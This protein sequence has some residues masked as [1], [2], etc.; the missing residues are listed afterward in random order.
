VTCLN[1]SSSASFVLSEIR[2]A[3]IMIFQSVLLIILFCTK[4]SLSCPEVYE[5]MPSRSSEIFL[6]TTTST[7]DCKVLRHLCCSQFNSDVSIRF[8]SGV[9][10][11]SR[12]FLCLRH[13]FIWITFQATIT[14]AISDSDKRSQ[15]AQ[16]YF[17]FVYLLMSKIENLR[18][19][20]NP[21]SS[22]HSTCTIV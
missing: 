8:P 9:S 10:H 22:V 5:V 18:A 17:P 3:C 2:L 20:E 12:I 15:T 19:S 7:L 13:S 6:P 21:E 11:A 14:R 1:S 16:L 4:H